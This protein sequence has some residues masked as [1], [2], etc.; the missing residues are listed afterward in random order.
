[1]ASPQHPR[2]DEACTFRKP[3]DKTIYA[4]LGSAKRGRHSQPCILEPSHPQTLSIC[5]RSQYRQ[6]FFIQ[7]GIWQPLATPAP[8]SPNPVGAPYFF[9]VA[10]ALRR[11]TPL[12]QPPAL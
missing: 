10:E 9:R 2:T 3:L 4:R 6:S 11:V 7:F 5:Q 1:M 8:A 12:G